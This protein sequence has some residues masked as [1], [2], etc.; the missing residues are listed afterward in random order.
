MKK[1]DFKKKVSP[2]RFEHGT[3]RLQNLRLIPWLRGKIQR[4]GGCMSDAV[5][6]VVCVCVSF[7]REVGVC[8]VLRC[9]HEPFLLYVYII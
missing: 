3:L 8:F 6:V 2:A 4:D 5:C 9:L 7:A 1:R